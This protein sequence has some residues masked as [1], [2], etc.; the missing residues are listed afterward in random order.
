[1]AVCPNYLVL[2]YVEGS[3]LV[4]SGKRRFA[5][6]AACGQSPQ[7]RERFQPMAEIRRLEQGAEKGDRPLCPLPIMTE[8]RCLKR[9]TE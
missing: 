9:G 1:M 2:Q 4:R 3:P 7:S 8:K 6:E 5:G